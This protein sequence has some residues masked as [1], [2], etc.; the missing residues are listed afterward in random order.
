M[1]GAFFI[2]EFSLFENSGVGLNKGAS[3]STHHNRVTTGK[4]LVY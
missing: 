3:A 2:F 1:S 4:N